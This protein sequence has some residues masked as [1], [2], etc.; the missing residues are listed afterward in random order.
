VLDTPRFL[1]KSIGDGATKEK[2]IIFIENKKKFNQGGQ[3]YN[4]LEG[5]GTQTRHYPLGGSAAVVG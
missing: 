5:S 1:R 4:P 2:L 3:F